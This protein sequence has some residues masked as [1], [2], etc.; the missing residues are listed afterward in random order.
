MGDRFFVCFFLVVSGLRNDNTVG[1]LG[2]LRST[3]TRLC[4]FDGGSGGRGGGRHRRRINDFA[5]CNGEGVVAFAGGEE[6]GD[7]D[8][9]GGDDGHSR[10]LGDAGDAVAAVEPQQRLV[11]GNGVPETRRRLSLVALQRLPENFSYL[12]FFVHYQ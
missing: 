8:G 1:C 7:D 2:L 5:G 6:E 9:H 3:G 12:F 10:E 11:L 4:G